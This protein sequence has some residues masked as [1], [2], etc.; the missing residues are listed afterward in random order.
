MPRKREIRQPL[1]PEELR[2]V[3]EY[4]VDL[5]PHG[6][7]ERAGLPGSRGSSLLGHPAVTGAIQIAKRRRQS[8]TEV[9]G[10]EIVRRW[11][12]A[13]STDVNELVQLRIGC[14]RFCW[15]EGFQY[16]RTQGEID[17][18]LATW[19]RE[20]AGKPGK[21]FP[22]LGGDGFNGNASPNPECPECFGD[23]HPR[24]VYQDTR[25]LSPGAR[26]LYQ[27]AEVTNGGGIKIN[28][29]PR[30][31][32]EELLARHLGILN[33]KRQLDNLDPDQLTDAQLDV[34]L[35]ALSGRGEL[36]TI[37]DVESEEV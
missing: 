32:L 17:R 30:R 8:R 16:Q 4:L 1:G 33:E 25:Y 9:F 2:F 36:P 21:V 34:A 3:E 29:R 18:D 27:G 6:A 5:D 20:H 28:L 24:V 11:Y 12:E 23:G 26:Y 7:A 19:E 35:T 15:G 31:D 14:C 13:W 37:V 10:D 22:V